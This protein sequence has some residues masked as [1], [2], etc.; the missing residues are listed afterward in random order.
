MRPRVKP[1]GL[2]RVPQ[3]IERLM[4]GGVA[5]GLEEALDVVHAEANRFH[6]KGGD[7]TLERFALLDEFVAVGAGRHRLDQRQERVEFGEC[8]S[9]LLGHRKNHN[10]TKSNSP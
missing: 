8:G 5:G 4:L 3:L 1:R 6:M 2:E 7:S 9:S 10:K